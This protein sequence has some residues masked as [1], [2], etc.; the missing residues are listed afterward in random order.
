MDTTAEYNAITQYCKDLFLKKTID[1]GTTWRIMPIASLTDLILMKLF[2]GR[3]TIVSE[4][5]KA[6]YQD[7]LNCTVFALIKLGLANKR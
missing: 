5:F 4:G 2:R 7:M 6:N 3:Q 1:H